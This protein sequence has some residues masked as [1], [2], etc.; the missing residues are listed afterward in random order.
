MGLLGSVRSKCSTA[1]IVE[2]TGVHLPAVHFFISIMSNFVMSTSS[3]AS[4]CASTDEPS[5]A[6]FTCEGVYTPP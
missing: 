1:A 3:C 4:V 5:S 6:C 2:E